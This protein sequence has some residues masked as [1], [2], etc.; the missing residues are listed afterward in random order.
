MMDELVRIKQ[1]VKPH[2][3]VLVL[4]SMTGQDA[5]DSA[6]RSARRSTTTA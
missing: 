6:R 4:D 5:V 3:V 2:D 1:K